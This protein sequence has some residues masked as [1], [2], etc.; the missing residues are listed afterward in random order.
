MTLRSRVQGCL[1]DATKGQVNRVLG[2]HKSRFLGDLSGTVV[3]LGAGTGANWDYY[4]P[5]VTIIAVEP[6]EAFHERLRRSAADAG[7]TVEIRTLR[8]EALDL[9]DD[10]ADAVVATLVL[11]SV[12]N[13]PAVLAEI[14][15]VLRPGGRF[16]FVEHVAAPSGTGRRRYQDIVAGPHRWVTEGC[17]T[18][19]R[20]EQLIREAGFELAEIDRFEHGPPFIYIRDYIAGVA[21]P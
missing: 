2:D 7:R 20:T 14:R 21:M 18:N 15:R 5:D 17:R 19:L 6:N 1:L 11:C 9:P 13:P 8:G 3:E 12:D 10:A 16:V 4:P